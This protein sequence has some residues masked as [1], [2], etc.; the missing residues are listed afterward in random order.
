MDTFCF[1]CLCRRHWYKSCPECWKCFLKTR[2][3]IEANTEG[4]S[5]RTYMI[6]LIH[7]KHSTDGTSRSPNAH[8]SKHEDCCV[9]TLNTD[10]IQTLVQ[11][12]IFCLGDIWVCDYVTCRWTYHWLYFTLA[13]CS[14][15]FNLS[16][17][18]FS[19]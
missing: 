15:D 1:C 17:R 3:W 12:W 19:H 18:R 4:Q 5:W 10:M 8:Q 9:N 11:T 7:C 13:C 14:S 16:T 2:I 6:L